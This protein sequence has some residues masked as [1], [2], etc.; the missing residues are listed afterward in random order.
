ME[1]AQNLHK[2]LH[3]HLQN[4]PSADRPVAD[5]TSLNQQKIG[6]PHLRSSGTGRAPARNAPKISTASTS[7]SPFDPPPNAPVPNQ[8]TAQNDAAD[9]LAL[10]DGARAVE[11]ATGMALRRL[12]PS[13][14]ATHAFVLLHLIRMAPA[15]RAD[16]QARM[17]IPGSTLASIL[18]ALEAENLIEMFVGDDRRRTMMVMTP[19]GCK[20]AR[21]AEQLLAR[22]AADLH[23]SRQYALAGAT[24]GACQ[25]G[26]KSGAAR[27]ELAGQGLAGQ[28]LFGSGLGGAALLRAA[29]VVMT[30]PDMARGR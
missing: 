19:A 20:A 18:G 13:L 14:G 6:K 24:S 15:T 22:I 25:S 3:M 5:R 7:R 16:L 21:C 26:E 29:I 4:M 28:G 17:T 23:R 1:K 2:N 11:Q 10:V 8:Q 27:Q 30:T 12:H 9:M